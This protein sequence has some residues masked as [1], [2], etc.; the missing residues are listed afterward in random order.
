MLTVK[1]INEVSFGKAGFSGY[2]PEDVDNFIDEV[3]ESFTQLQAERDDAVQQSAQLNQQME[4]LNGQIAEL[5]AKN[6]ELQKKLAILAQKIES[7]REEEDGIK[8]AILSAQKIG[9]DSIQE[10]KGKAAVMLA[11][12]EENAKKILES[13]RDD[14]AKAA[15]EYANQVEQKRNELEEMKRQ[16]SAF[17]VSLL[18]M[19]KKHLESINHIPSFRFKDSAPASETVSQPES[20]PEPEPE[21]EPQP[22]PQPEPEPEIEPEPEPEPVPQPAPQTKARPVEVRKPQPARQPAPRREQPEQLSMEGRTLHDKVDY[23]REQLRREP[24]YDYHPDDDDLSQVGIDLKAYS[25]IP[26]SLQKEKASNF[27]NLEFGDNVDLGRKRR[28]K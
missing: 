12:A 5:K 26:E 11:D 15:R 28:R 24:D 8:E 7:Y 18:E 13:A 10:A 16:V 17:R 21:P 23:T 3:V 20:R 25:D 4:E 19:Y 9:K 22:V 14:A 1:E 27:S 2:K 6:G